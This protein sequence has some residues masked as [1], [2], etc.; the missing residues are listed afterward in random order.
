MGRRGAGGTSLR[1]PASSSFRLGFVEGTPVPP[2]SAPPAPP[3][4]GRH[5]TAPRR[6]PATPRYGQG[7][8]VAPLQPEL[9]QALLLD[10]RAHVPVPLTGPARWGCRRLPQPRRP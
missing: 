8:Q 7:R 5:G 10:G 9:A 4:P 6:R 2:L 1:P 3:R